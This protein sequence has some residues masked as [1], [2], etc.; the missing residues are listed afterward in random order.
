MPASPS[1]SLSSP[2]APELFRPANH[3]LLHD[4]RPQPPVATQPA[5]PSPALLPTTRGPVAPAG[6]RVNTTC[7][8]DPTPPGSGTCGQSS[9]RPGWKSL[10]SQRVRMSGEKR[11][12]RGKTQQ[13]LGVSRALRLSL[14]YVICS[15]PGR[16]DDYLCHLCTVIS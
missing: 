14:W 2:P 6:L 8:V 3:V 9:C 7:P 5:S 12:F 16:H 10:L 15:N 13:S 11:T 1:P 4:Q